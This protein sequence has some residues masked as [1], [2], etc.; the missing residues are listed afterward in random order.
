MFMNNVKFK[1]RFSMYLRSL[2]L[3]F[4]LAHF[5]IHLKCYV[6]E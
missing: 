2:Y 4:L 5:T 6:Y 1:S 3:F